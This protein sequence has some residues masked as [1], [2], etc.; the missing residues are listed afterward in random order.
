MLQNELFNP[1]IHSW[2]IV[3]DKD[4]FFLG[5]LI[6]IYNNVVFENVVH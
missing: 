5:T 3:A 4:C 1:E 6:I 2:F